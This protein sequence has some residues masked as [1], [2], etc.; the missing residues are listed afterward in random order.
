MVRRQV[1]RKTRTVLGSSNDE[2][3]KEGESS[4]SRMD[5]SGVHEP[6]RR[7]EE[8]QQLRA[9]APGLSFSHFLF[10]F[11]CIELNE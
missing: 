2:K 7:R 5:A 6:K 11:G 1:K 8:E 9:H 3:K 4:F 10:K